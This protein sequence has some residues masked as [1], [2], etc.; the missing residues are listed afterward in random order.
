M[1]ENEFVKRHKWISQETLLDRFQLPA[2]CLGRTP[3][4]VLPR[5]LPRNGYPGLILGAGLHHA[6]VHHGG[7]RLPSTC[8]L[9]LLEWASAHPQPGAGIVVD[10]WRISKSVLRAEAVAILRRHPVSCSTGT[11]ASSCPVGVLGIVLHHSLDRLP[12]SAAGSFV[13]LTRWALGRFS[14]RPAACWITMC[15]SSSTF[16][17]RA[18]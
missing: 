8:A 18:L 6:R 5:G 1:M 12:R 9:A 7:D 15:A 11:R 13:S 2:W 14:V 10:T 16:S 3:R 17:R 4:T